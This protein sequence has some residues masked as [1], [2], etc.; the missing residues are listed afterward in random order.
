MDSNDDPINNAPVYA[1]DTDGELQAGGTGQLVNTDSSGEAD[2]DLLNTSNAGTDGTGTFDAFFEENLTVGNQ[3]N[4]L[5]TH[6]STSQNDVEIDGEVTDNTLPFEGV[7]NDENTEFRVLVG[8]SSGTEVVNT[9]LG[10]FDTLASNNP[11]VNSATFTNGGSP[12]QYD[13]DLEAFG[14]AQTYRIEANLDGFDAA[15]GDVNLDPG[16]TGSQNIRLTRQINPDDITVDPS[17]ET[18]GLDATVNTTTNVTTDDRPGITGSPLEDSPVDVSV[19][20][21]DDPSGQLSAANV[22][23]DPA[24]PQETRADGKAFFDVS[25]DLSNVDEDSF[26]DNIGVDLTYT[27]T[28]NTSVTATQNLTFQPTVRGTGTISGEVD[29][30]VGQDGQLGVEANNVEP[31]EDA[32]VH[33]VRLSNIQQN[34][35]TI[36]NVSEGETYRLGTYDSDGT[37]EEADVRGDYL[38]TTSEVEVVQNETSLGF[39]VDNVNTNGNQNVS[40]HFL[41]NVSYQV[42]K[43]DTVAGD[44]QNSSN[45]TGPSGADLSGS[46]LFDVTGDELTYDAVSE[47]FA[48]D[49]YVPNSTVNSVG[50][51]ELLNVPANG[52]SGTQYVVIAGG[53]NTGDSD[54]QFGYANFAGYEIVDVYPNSVVGSG[55]SQYDVDLSVQEF[56]R[57]V[58][59]DYSLDVVAE[60]DNEELVKQVRTET[61][62]DVDVVVNVTAENQETGSVSADAA[63]GQVVNLSLIGDA[64]GSLSSDSVT[65]D[66]EF[67]DGQPYATATFEASDTSAGTTNVSAE[68][69]NDAN[70]EYNTSTGDGVGLNDDS[71]QAQIDVF[72]TVEITG[73]VVNEFDTNIPGAQIELFTLDNAGNLDESLDNTTSGAGGSYVFTGV[74]TGQKLAITATALDADGNE[75]ENTRILNNGNQVDTSLGGEDVVVQ[76]AVE[77][78]PLEDADFQVSDLS[79]PSEVNTSES[80]TVTATVTNDGA[81]EDT[82]DV[83]FRLNSTTPLDEDTVVDTTSV[84]LASDQSETVE[85]DVTAPADAGDYTHGVFTENDDQTADLTVTAE[86][87]VGNGALGVNLAPSTVTAN[88]E[89]DVTVTVTN[90][91]SGD[92]VEG[93]TVDISDLGLS[94]TTDANG[95][96]T[97]SVNASAAGDYPIDVSADGYTDASTTLTVEEDAPAYYTL[98]LSHSIADRDVQTT[99]ISTFSTHRQSGSTALLPHSVYR[100]TR[101]HTGGLR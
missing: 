76:G 48:E 100:Y 73:D 39:N 74:E 1:N 93:A 72:T 37:F 25:L 38:T 80:L 8:G 5:V 44:F 14:N 58:F 83:T 82:Q 50:D 62:T 19:D 89:T 78:Q 68:T 69:T 23:I 24:P 101:T 29:E 27:A 43:Y 7:D 90:Q 94:N 33:A 4:Q 55:A 81:I 21:V 42:Q 61:G 40:V 53:S 57:D 31:A 87:N 64:V 45:V 20:N 96:V 35:L 77:D 99:T 15:T 46:T 92:A 91:T 66:N 79:A 98:S 97:F 60:N 70:E 41:E 13:I 12:P 75:V 52:T 95:E 51:F 36:E 11:Y 63:E 47:R 32:Q 54:T 59:Y 16:D 88:E 2:I 86:D 26:Q 56:E 3:S 49:P 67:A 18:V 85:F 84:T 65:V 22:T 9:T 17:S 28:D 71:N 30:I 34:T 10:D 6:I